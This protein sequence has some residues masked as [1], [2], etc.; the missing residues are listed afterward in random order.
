MKNENEEITIG[1]PPGVEA[2]E[3]P[4][5]DVAYFEKGDEIPLFVH[6][7]DCDAARRMVYRIWL[8]RHPEWE[9]HYEH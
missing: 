5:G 8:K 6:P 4:I 3:Y 2:R 9:V 7:W 1:L